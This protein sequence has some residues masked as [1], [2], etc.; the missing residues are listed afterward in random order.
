MALKRRRMRILV[1]R[2][3]APRPRQGTFVVEATIERSEELRPERLGP[4]PNDVEDPEIVR[5]LWAPSRTLGD[6]PE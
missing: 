3:V 5:P 4:A 2:D 6:L 1:I